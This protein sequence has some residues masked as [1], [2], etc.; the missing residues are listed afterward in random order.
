MKE[1]SFLYSLL[2][3]LMLAMLYQV[4]V[5]FEKFDGQEKVKEKEVECVLS[6]SLSLLKG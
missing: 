1:V 6:T 2:K 5:V 4:L 3:T